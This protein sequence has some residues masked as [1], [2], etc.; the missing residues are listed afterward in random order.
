MERDISERTGLAPTQVRT[1]LLGGVTVDEIEA[2]AD[3]M[4]RH[5]GTAPSAVLARTAARIA[6]T[7]SPEAAALAASTFGGRAG[8]AMA[9][10]ITGCRPEDLM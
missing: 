10:A 4:R 5:H 1:L 2:A 6:R 9:R 8:A 3:Y 7:S